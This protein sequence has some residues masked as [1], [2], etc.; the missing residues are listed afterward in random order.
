[1][2]FCLVD[3]LE[4]MDLKD[5]LYVEKNNVLLKEGVR[6]TDGFKIVFFLIMIIID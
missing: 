5:L 3:L 1:M 2:S 4:L 6:G